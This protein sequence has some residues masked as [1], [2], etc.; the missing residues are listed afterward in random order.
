MASRYDDSDVIFNIVAINK[1]KNE[2]SRRVMSMDGNQ[3]TKEDIDNMVKNEI[4][5]LNSPN[6]KDWGFSEFGKPAVSQPVS[7]K[8]GNKVGFVRY[9]IEKN[10]NVSSIL[11][12]NEGKEKLYTIMKA[13]WKGTLK[14]KV[15]G[16][17][18]NY[19]PDN[20][21]IDGYGTQTEPKLGLRGRLKNNGTVEYI[22][23]YYSDGIEYTLQEDANETLTIDDTDLEFLRNE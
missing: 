12:T 1:V 9:P 23:V 8:G 20:T 14:K 16:Q 19:F 21:F 3:L 22:I 18:L 11:Q 17:P 5:E 4:N 7:F 6:N 13:K 2:V 10:E 15:N